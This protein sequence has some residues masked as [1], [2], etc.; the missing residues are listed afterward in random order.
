MPQKKLLDLSKHCHCFER[1]AFRNF[2]AH[3]CV[4]CETYTFSHFHSDG[5]KLNQE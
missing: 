3:T 5:K 2:F 4:W 1:F